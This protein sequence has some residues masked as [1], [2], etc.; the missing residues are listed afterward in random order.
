MDFPSCLVSQSS[1]PDA[2]IVGGGGS[3]PGGDFFFFFFLHSSGRGMGHVYY[4]VHVPQLAEY[5]YSAILI[6]MFWTLSSK[7]ENPTVVSP[8]RRHPASGTD[9]WAAVAASR[10][11]DGRRLVLIHEPGHGGEGRRRGYAT[12]VDRATRRKRLNAKMKERRKKNNVVSK[13]PDVAEAGCNNT[14]R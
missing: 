14:V 8:R 12:A 9:D 1:R 13:C 2:S 3:Y 7:E 5:M 4:L 6:T 11:R 10:R